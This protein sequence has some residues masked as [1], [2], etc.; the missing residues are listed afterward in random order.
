MKNNVVLLY[1]EFGSDHL[2]VISMEPGD[3]L[4]E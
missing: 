4:E 2:S 1:S 3:K